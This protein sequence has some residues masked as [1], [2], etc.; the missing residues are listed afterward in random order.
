MKRSNRKSVNGSPGGFFAICRRWICARLH[1]LDQA[2]PAFGRTADQ[3]EGGESSHTERT[4]LYR[5]GALIRVAKRRFQTPFDVRGQLML[6]AKK[7]MRP[8]SSVQGDVAQSVS[9]HSLE[10]VSG[11]RS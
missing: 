7:R 5:K 3:Y 4:T 8:P 11:P 2:Q 1:D 9:G 10:V 6:V